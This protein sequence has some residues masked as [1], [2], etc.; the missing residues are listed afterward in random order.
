[1][2]RKQLEQLDQKCL[3]EVYDDEQETN[4]FSCGIYQSYF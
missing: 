1:M 4:D 3:Y 2:N